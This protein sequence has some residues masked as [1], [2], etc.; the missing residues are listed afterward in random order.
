MQHG[1]DARTVGGANEQH[2]ED[3]EDG[4]NRVH[5]T[6]A[7]SVRE[8]ENEG[9]PCGRAEVLAGNRALKAKINHVIDTG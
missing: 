4:S 2:A 6:E 9:V 3:D 7:E 1:V 5:G 8:D